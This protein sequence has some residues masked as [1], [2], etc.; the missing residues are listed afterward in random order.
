MLPPIICWGEVLW[1]R[2]PDGSV[3]GGAVANVAW[4]LAMLGAPVALV[5]RVG[6]DEPGR[7]AIAKLAARG[8]D[9]SLIQ[10]DPER[11]TGEVEVSTERGEPR[12]RLVPDRAWER[13][14]ATPAALAAIAAAP[15]IVYGTIAQRAG[16][17]AW[18]AAVAAARGL[19]V[20]DPNLRPGK[21]D[22]E[23]VAA[24]LETADVIK[25][26]DR[27]LDACASA[28]DQPDLLGWLLSRRQPPARL[29]ALTRGPMGSTLHTRDHRVEVPAI[30]AIPG[31][32][33][34]GCGDAYLAVVVH[35]LVA[36]WPLGE[37]GEIA[38]RWAATVAS[39]RGAT[40]QLDADT[41]AR[42]VER[43][44]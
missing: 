30:A 43:D 6:D 16:L 24:A 25:L 9:T 29:V 4:H 41:I 3:L 2:F 44:P 12:Y 32:D 20:L 26:G 28:V 19:K 17:D 35:G 7:D 34:V 22:R 23:A 36:G 14:E 38:A 31:G 33:N 8:V 39:A 1:D 13:I 15:A 11:A 42:I 18:R 37:T 5:T 21:E 10:V 27:E 40:P